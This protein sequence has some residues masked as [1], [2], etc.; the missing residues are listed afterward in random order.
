VSSRVGIWPTRWRTGLCRSLLEPSRRQPR[1]SVSSAGR[2]GV[3]A[4]VPEQRVR[5]AVAAGRDEHAAP[6]SQLRRGR[7]ACTHHRAAEDDP[8]VEGGFDERANILEASYPASAH[9]RTGAGQPWL[10]GVRSTWV[11][12]GRSAA[13]TSDGKIRSAAT[14]NVGEQRRLAQMQGDEPTTASTIAGMPPDRAWCG[15]PDVGRARAAR[16]PARAHAAR[17][18]QPDG[19][20]FRSVRRRAK[21]NR[22]GERR[23]HGADPDRRHRPK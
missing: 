20:A 17:V 18:L 14:A 2:C 15:D 8:R 5:G 4:S 16:R 6:P 23:V 10:T 12:S 21:R 11:F 19:V 9:G 7:S 22:R 13:P 3:L 1:T